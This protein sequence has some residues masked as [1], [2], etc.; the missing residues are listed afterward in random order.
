MGC[1]IACLPLVRKW[2][3][4][5]WKDNIEKITDNATYDNKYIVTTKL[6]LWAEPSEDKLLIFTF[7]K[8]YFRIRILLNYVA[9]FMQFCG[10]NMLKIESEMNFNFI[11]YLWNELC[12]FISTSLSSCV[13]Y[14]PSQKARGCNSVWNENSFQILYYYIYFGK[15]MLLLFLIFLQ[16]L[17]RK[18]DIPKCNLTLQITSFTPFTR[19]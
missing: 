4:M 13:F 9:T 11:Q 7:L 16:L 2:M 12:V 1:W 14:I 17:S 19:Q 3:N 6:L 18:F 15:H 8:E 5:F 10:F